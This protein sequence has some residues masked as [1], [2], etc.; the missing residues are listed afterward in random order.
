MKEIPRS[1]RIRRILTAFQALLDLNIPLRA[2]YAGYFIVLSLFPALLLVLGSVRYTGL[3]VEDLLRLLQHILPEALMAPAQ[4]LIYQAW[5]SVT[6]VLAGL[7]ALTALWSA[8]KGV[9]GLMSGLN[10]VYGV[11]ES[12]SF[13]YTRA[14]SVLYALVFW[15]VVMLTL[16]LFVLGGWLL[17]LPALRFVLLA[18]VQ[19]LL[20][21]AMYMVLPNGRNRFLSSLPGGLLAAVGWLAFSNL[22]SMYVARFSGYAN[23]FGSLYAI[24]LCMLW[25]YIC[26]NILFYGG[27]LNRYLSQ[28]K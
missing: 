6:G 12:R 19:T 14:V 5:H 3:Q 16:V 17:E 4:R 15:L 28:K 2:A 24:A 27:A 25:L 21:T 20:F 1:G 11:A 23:V 7:S 26:M 9:Y 10:A 8:S 18:A 13:L 22:Y